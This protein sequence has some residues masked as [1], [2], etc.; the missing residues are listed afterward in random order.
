MD[1]GVKVGNFVEIKKSKL[2]KNAK[3]SHL[4]YIGDASIGEDTNVGAGTIFCNYD[5]V[6]KHKIE[7]GKD[8]FIGSNTSLV[9]PLKI[10]DRA[11]I[12][13]GSTVTDEV[14]N[15]SLALGRARQV[16]KYRK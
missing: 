4:S 16:N 11:M 12:G 8:S 6:L 15:D 9:A 5:G 1:D 7:V 3:A 13:A 14:E 2:G 10:G